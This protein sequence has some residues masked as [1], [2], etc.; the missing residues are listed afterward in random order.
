MSQ[1]TT[2]LALL[3]RHYLKPGELKPGG[4]FV[5]EVGNNGS[6][7]GG[8][9]CDAIYVGF[10]SVSGRILV[11]HE[12]K[13][14]RADWL[15]ELNKPGKADAWAD[16][17]HEWWV[18]VP[19]PA[20]VHAGELPDGW[21]L[22][23]PGGG[24][25]TRMRVHTKAHRKDPRTHRPSWDSVRSVIAR[26]DTLRAGAVAEGIT[27]ATTEIRARYDLRF[28]DRVE[29]EIARRAGSQPD[30]AELARRVALIE[31][32]LGARID[33][34]ENR[35]GYP[36]MGGATV[37]VAELGMIADAV[38]ATGDVRRAI[39]TLTE[40]WGN[41]VAQTTKALD[42]LDSALRRLR[43]VAGPA[44]VEPDADRKSA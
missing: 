5:P 12:I 40:G 34:D 44:D 32:A 11:G 18:V 31:S 39:L 35:R 24:R 1:T 38:R 37:S 22:M 10:T 9:R 21:G 8:R 3:Q 30:A 6:F 36:L 33:W 27:A 16:E 25:T 13:V 20:I 15:A 2:L 4:A 23:H 29:Q 42:A 14:S 7:G 28:Q 19:D 26:L 43:A 17:C 41:P